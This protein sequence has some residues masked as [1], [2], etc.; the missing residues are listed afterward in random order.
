MLKIQQQGLAKNEGTDNML[1]NIAHDKAIALIHERDRIYKAISESIPQIVWTAEP[2]GKIDYFNKRWFEYTG[3]TVDE[4]YTDSKT[5][6]HPEDQE[7]Y[8]QF[9]A[10]S[11]S[12]GKEYS[13]EYRFRRASDAMYRWHLGRGTPYYNEEGQILKWFGTCTDIH[14]Q[15]EHTELI[16]R[17]NEDLEDKVR[18]RTNQLIQQ[19]DEMRLVKER[20]KANFERLQSVMNSMLLGTIIADEHLRIVNINLQF[21]KMFDLAQLPHELTGCHMEELFAVTAPKIV[22]REKNFSQLRRT[23]QEQIAVQNQEIQLIDGRVL[24]RLYVPVYVDQELRGHLLMYRDISHERRIDATKSEFM[25]LASHQLRTP[26]TAIRWIF[27]KLARLSADRFSDDEQKLLQ[28]GKHAAKRMAN[29]IDTMLT[30]ARIEAG[31]MPLHLTEI[32]ICSMFQ[33]LSEL[34][35]ED[36]KNK[37]IE[38]R[39]NCPD[40]IMFKTDIGL[41]R[42]VLRN[43]VSNAIKYTPQNGTIILTGNMNHGAIEISIRDTGYG[44]PSEQQKRIFTKFFRGSNVVGLDTEGSGLG[45]YL[46]H[47]LMGT[48]SGTVSFSS[49]QQQGTTFTLLFPSQLDMETQHDR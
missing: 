12:T 6:I 3:L 40:A 9:W 4:T 44:I 36:L 41:L 7:R 24:S 2:S 15:K 28:E 37:N 46:V 34:Y 26:L 5:A 17:L 35:K 30:I 20:D 14:D 21:C 49:L 38:L 42:E 48:L 43:L 1:K 11:L 13:I 8:R 45:L 47:L 22:E 39:L 33:E 27:G 19:M 29:T 23:L 10:D 32:D 25:S 16:R 31:Q 18:V